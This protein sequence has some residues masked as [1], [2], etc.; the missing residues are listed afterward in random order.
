M[1]ATELLGIK[2]RVCS[3]KLHWIQEAT[4]RWEEMHECH[5]VSA[6]PRVVAPVR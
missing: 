4:V 6:H 5:K 2:T 1:Y 3:I